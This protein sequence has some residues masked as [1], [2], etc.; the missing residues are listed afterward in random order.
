MTTHNVCQR[1]GAIDDE[2]GDVLVYEDLCPYETE[3]SYSNEE[4]YPCMCCSECR[5]DCNMST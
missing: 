4:L 2:D 3:M 1:C 5:A